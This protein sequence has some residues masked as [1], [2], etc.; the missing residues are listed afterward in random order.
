[1]ARNSATDYDSLE[2]IRGIK[3]RL[4]EKKKKNPKVRDALRLNNNKNIEVAPGVG[5]LFAGEKK[6]E[7][8]YTL[9]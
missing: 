7:N 5:R 8:I 2:K 3:R 1:M 6:S 4:W 9:V